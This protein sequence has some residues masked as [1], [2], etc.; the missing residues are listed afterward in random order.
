MK[1]LLICAILALHLSANAGN[2]LK[3]LAQ[4]VYR[5]ARGE[6]RK[7]QLAVAQVAINRTRSGKFPDNICD[8]MTQPGQYPW[9]R[10]Y[11]I[12]QPD[13]HSLK[14]AREVIMGEHELKDFKA[15]HFHAIT[16]KPNWGFKRVAT[17]GNH[18]FY[19]V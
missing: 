9:V 16:V 10:K 8:V 7:G 3:C 4:I 15:T 13:Y 2:D 11:K 12:T 1:K 6:S 19:K 5:E 17:I 14:I 18:I